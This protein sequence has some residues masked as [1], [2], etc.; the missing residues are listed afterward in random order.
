[1]AEKCWVHMVTDDGE[2]FTITSKSEKDRDIYYL[3][4]KKNGSY[5][6]IS[7]NSDPSSFEVKVFG[8]REELED[9]ES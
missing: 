8:K 7:R 5:K 4:Q 9:D 1:M 2:E 6:R 3:N